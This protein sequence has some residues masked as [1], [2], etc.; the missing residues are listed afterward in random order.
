MEVGLDSPSAPVS[1]VRRLPPG[2][3]S[4]T[5]LENAKAARGAWWSDGP[6]RSG[7][8]ERPKGDRVAQLLRRRDRVLPGPSGRAGQDVPGARLE[9]DLPRSPL[10]TL[11]ALET[12]ATGRGQRHADDGLEGRCV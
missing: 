6:R 9:R 11:A 7:P 1:T 5:S 8:P 10:V 4:W 2:E 3:M 12:Q